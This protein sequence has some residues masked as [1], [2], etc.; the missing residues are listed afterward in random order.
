MNLNA[1][2]DKIYIQRKIE[3][4]IEEVYKV[5]EINEETIDRAVNY[6]FDVDEAETLWETQIDL[7]PVKVLN[8][9]NKILK[10]YD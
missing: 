4:W 6:E 5:E 1:I 2:M 3:V 8:H 7:G 9:N 10:E